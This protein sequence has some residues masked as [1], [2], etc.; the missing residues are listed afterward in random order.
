MSAI[1]LASFNLYHFAAPGI[2]WHERDKGKTYSDDEWVHKCAW[3]STTLGSMDADIVAFQEVVSVVALKKLAGD[4]G[5]RYFAC[6]TEPRFDKDDPGVYSNGTVAIASRFPISTSQEIKTFDQII[7]QTLLDRAAMYSRRPLRCLIDLP[8]LGETI[9]YAAHFKS[10]GAFFN[11]DIVDVIDDWD[12]KI[13]RFFVERMYADIDQ[14]SKR[15]AEAGALYLQIRDD[16]QQDLDRPVIALGDLNEGPQSHT[17][18]ILTQAD[19]IFAIGSVPWS[20]VPPGHRFRRYTHRLY[21]AYCLPAHAELERPV[22]YFSNKR[23]SVLDYAIV[24]NGL[25]PDNPKR[26]GAVTKHQVHDGHFEAGTSKRLSSD[27][28]PVVV[29]IEPRKRIA[30]SAVIGL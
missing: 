18:S 27:H 29:T 3:I 19:G 11:D 24:S 5:Y 2:H 17:L 28:A 12:A 1:K 13:D 22:T 30:K 26:C 16:L 6:Q 15:A 10:Q 7:D 21:D 8:G 23:S 20:Q 4:A 9:V 25:H 14:V